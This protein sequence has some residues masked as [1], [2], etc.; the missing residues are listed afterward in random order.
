VGCRGPSRH[1]GA[2]SSSL[3]AII[4]IALCVRVFRLSCVPDSGTD[5]RT[6]R[7]TDR[8]RGQLSV[9]CRPQ[10]QPGDLRTVHVHGNAA[11]AAVDDQSPCQTWAKGAKPPKCRLAPILV[12][13][14]EVNCAKYSHFDRFCSQN[15]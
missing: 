4:S 9:A 13:N 3:N 7:Q 6:D 11:V 2:T 8:Q 5:G 12:K 14:R 15:L 10:L 1:L